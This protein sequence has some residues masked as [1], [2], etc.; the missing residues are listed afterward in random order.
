MKFVVEQASKGGR[1]GKL[2]GLRS[3]PTVVHDTPL[4]MISTLGGS[5]P[6]LTQVRKWK[7]LISVVR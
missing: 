3:Q 2:T 7:I 1:L 4:S 5:A 6:H